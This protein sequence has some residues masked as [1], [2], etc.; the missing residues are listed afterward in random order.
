MSAA[1]DTRATTEELLEMVF[2]A[3]SMLRL[4]NENQSRAVR[5]IFSQKGRP[6]FK[7]FKS[8]EKKNIVMGLDRT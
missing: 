6:H 3:W 1:R 5:P 4:S 7:T 8:L 2:S